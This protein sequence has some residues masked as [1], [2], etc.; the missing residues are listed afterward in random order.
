M[1]ERF[2]TQLL[3]IENRVE[4]DS[5]VLCQI[6]LSECGTLSSETGTI[7][8]AIRLPCSH[9]LGSACI[10]TWLRSRNSCPL[11]RRTF[12]PLEQTAEDY[13]L[14]SDDQG[15][16]E[17]EE[18][19]DI[20]GFCDMINEGIRL[21]PFALAIAHLM[22]RQLDN[23]N[24]FAG[25]TGRCK[26]AVIMYMVSHIMHEARSLD[27]VSE[28]S[29]VF[30][31]HIRYVYGLVARNRD[32]LIPPCLLTDFCASKVEE[33]IAC[34][35][36]P[37]FTDDTIMDV[38]RDGNSDEE[39]DVEDGEDSEDE[40]DGEDREDSEDEEEEEDKSGEEKSD[41]NTIEYNR[42][43]EQL[44]S[45]FCFDLG[46]DKITE[47]I[48]LRL[49]QDIVPLLGDNCNIRL[50]VA[51]GILVGSHLLG[52]PCSMTALAGVV[53][54]NED[55]IKSVYGW[56][57]PDRKDVIYPATAEIIGLQNPKRAL[58]IVGPLSWPEL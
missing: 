52:S 55:S 36:A 44:C 37:M 32:A 58:E 30:A 51:V 22:V 10:C 42:F 2:L 7:E 38:D 28:A 9:V 50:P 49:T 47:D 20:V 8:I 5:G 25:H 11:C 4:S 15:E 3:R 23:A 34:L 13:T 12:F 29:D 48:C 14:L 21:S 16:E 1:S 24:G 54:V 26:A 56:I 53:G 57:Y 35:P 41:E 31:D 40:E 33:F 43:L 45:I 6:C 46:Y 19:E 27:Q 39:G 17:E 18:E